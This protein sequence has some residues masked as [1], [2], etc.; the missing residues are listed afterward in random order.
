MGSKGSVAA[1]S[2][3]CWQDLFLPGARMY[4]E[5]EDTL[6]PV[7]DHPFSRS[8]L[9]ATVSLALGYKPE[10]DLCPPQRALCPKSDTG[11][12]KAVGD[13]GPHVLQGVRKRFLEDTC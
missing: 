9:R 5:R 12:K 7:I 10:Q 6:S 4:G 13:A 11:K 2:G 1:G 3:I 8:S